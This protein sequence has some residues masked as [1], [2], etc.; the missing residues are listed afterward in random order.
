VSNDLP[1]LD[2]I[3]L[4]GYELN[5]DYYLKKDYN[6]ISIASEELPAL[7]EWVNMLVQLYTEKKLITKQEIKEIEAEAFNRLET[8]PDFTGKKTDTNLS[9]QLVLQEDVKKAHRRYAVL[10]GWCGRL[11]NLQF[12]LQS[13]LDLV[14]ST[15]STRRKVFTD[16]PEQRPES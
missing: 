9:R 14:R 11:I 1:T 10:V 12:S 8:D 4:Q 5:V 13:K 15:E 3:K 2:P 16:D 7:I 6:D